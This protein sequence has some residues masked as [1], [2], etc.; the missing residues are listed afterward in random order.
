[1]QTPLLQSVPIAQV[2]FASQRGQVPLAPPQSTSLSSPFLTTSEQVGIWQRE[3]AHT[4]LRQSV[5]A[6]QDAPDAQFEPQM[7]PQSTSDSVRLI[8]PSL[9][10]A[11]WQMALVHTRLAQSAAATQCLSS[12]H[13]LHPDAGPPQSTSDSVPL[14]TPSAQLGCWQVPL[15]QT[16][17]EQSPGAPQARLGS[18]ATQ[19]PPPQSTSV[20]VPFLTL[21]PQPAA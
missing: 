8:T 10:V 3:P 1:V 7:P 12:A 11:G 21:S 4:P 2:R 6:L 18:Q 15:V 14:L 13:A 9:Q 5:G 16:P 19:A 17:L 20:S